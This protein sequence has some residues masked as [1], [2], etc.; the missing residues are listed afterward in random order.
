[1]IRKSILVLCYLFFV[2]TTFS[3]TTDS[4]L[5]LLKQKVKSF[6]LAEDFKVEDFTINGFETDND[7]DE[8]LGRLKPNGSWSDIDYTDSSHARWMPAMHWKRLFKLSLLLTDNKSRFYGD[9]IV[10][11]RVLTAMEYWTIAKPV[12]PNYWWNAA[13]VPLYMGPAS[14]LLEDKLSPTLKQK[15][16]A[17]LNLSVKPDYY[18]YHGVATGQ[19]LL[20]LANAHLYSS[21]L[22][23]DNQGLDR[24]FSSVAAEIK[25]TDK[26]GIQA[27]NSFH[28]HGAMLYS[29]GYGKAFVMRAASYVYLAKG[30]AWEF[31]KAKE[32]ILSNY[33]LEGQ[34]W[35]T[36]NSFFD[37]NAF[38]REIT[39]E[40]FAIYPLEQACKML[41][42][43][44]TVNEPEYQKFRNQLI[45]G[46]RKTPLVGNRN[47]YC[48]DFMVHQR[49]NYYFSVKGT[50]NRTVGSESGNG[51]NQKGFY[52]GKGNTFI[53]RRGDEY[54]DIFP[55][56]NWRKLPGTIIEQSTAVLPLF[57]WGKG[58]KGKTAFV[59]GVSDGMYGCFGYDYD[60]QNVVAKRAW[61]MFDKEI[62]CLVAGLNTNGENDLFQTINQC[63]LQGEVKVDKAILKPETRLTKNKTWVIHDSVAYYTQDLKSNL[64]I[65]NNLQTGSWKTI[66]TNGRGDSI[67][68]KVFT[69]GMKIG[70]HVKNVSYYYA[71][72]PGVSATDI[73]NYSFNKEIDILRNDSLI[74]AVCHKKLNQMQAVFYHKGTL[75]LPWNRLS[76]E[77]RKAGLVIVKKTGNILKIYI[78]QANVNRQFT[79]DLNANTVFENE[80]VRI[81]GQ[82][83]IMLH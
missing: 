17:A 2:C 49:P 22:T 12:C 63:L 13:G 46:Q 73:K 79:M 48:S 76:L 44:D 50:S 54:K 42:L 19:N 23:N 24:V 80:N 32:Q 29:F 47:F 30:T 10:L 7:I 1:M 57:D 60:L 5:L 71:M 69:L 78:N 26:E 72:L 37:Y 55:V 20:W 27:D 36:R 35:M 59:Y 83:Q 25:I 39:R 14:F 67:Q 70:S 15:I 61:F 21:L 75:S 51:E 81:G 65:Q 40:N 28:Q 33:L 8:L 45:T 56:W 77:L 64:Q 43:I 18:N 3:Q 58:T 53:V 6:V 11:N 16:V 34:Q 41:A 62:V 38:G 31:P 4:V 66:D 68:S 74:Q 82:R 52:L 9:T